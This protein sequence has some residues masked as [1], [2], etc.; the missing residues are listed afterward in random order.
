MREI[1]EAYLQTPVKNAIVTVPAYF[2]DAQRLATKDAGR[3]AGLNVIQILNEPTAA[4]IAYGHHRMSTTGERNVLIFDLGGGTTDVSLLTVKEEARGDIS[5][6]AK[7]LRRL[8]TACEIA[9]FFCMAGNEGLALESDSTNSRGQKMCGGPLSMIHV[10]NQAP[11]GVSKLTGCFEI[12]A[13]GI[14]NVTA[15]EKTTGLFWN[16][17]RISNS[18]AKLSEEEINTM[19]MDAEEYEVEYD[20]YKKKVKSKADLENYAY[21][22]RSSVND[23]EIGARLS[24]ASKKKIEAAIDEVIPLLDG[25]QLAEVYE[26]EEK[27]RRLE[28][29]SKEEKVPIKGRNFHASHPEHELELQNSPI[30]YDCDGCKERGIGRRYRCDKCNVNL[31][32]DCMFGGP[33]ISHEFFPN[34]TFEF[35]NQPPPGRNCYCDA[36]GKT[37]FGFHYCCR[38]KNVDFHPCCRNLKTELTLDGVTFRLRGTGL[39]DCVLCKKATEEGRDRGWSYVSEDN[40]FQFHVSCAVEM[41][42]DDIDGWIRGGTTDDRLD[43]KNLEQRGVGF[44]KRRGGTGKMCW[45]IAKVFLRIDIGIV[46]GDPTTFISLI[47]SAVAG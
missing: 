2:N 24:Y 30:P 45:K 31:H 41:M 10:S 5:G 40:R 3:I 11:R 13:S 7:A 8:R 9:E 47:V 34:S 19:V 4:A 1:A 38:E 16:N 39:S 42:D 27:L 18:S 21:S 26:Y 14:L 37:I 23:K 15:R 28:S 17:F 35:L 12:D 6:N 22:M 46:L 20:E 43:W 32:E 33:P 29:I 25:N 36:C 44:L